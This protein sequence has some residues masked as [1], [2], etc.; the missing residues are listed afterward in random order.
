MLPIF[1][2]RIE[3]FQGFAGQKPNGSDEPTDASG[4]EAASREPEQYDLIAIF[5]V[6]I[7]VSHALSIR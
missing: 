7:V 2:D 5:V 1:E 4:Y 3:V 6:L